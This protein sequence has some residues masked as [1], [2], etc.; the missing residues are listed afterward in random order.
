MWKDEKICL[1]QKSC[2]FIVGFG[3]V[4]V[5]LGPWLDVGL[6]CCWFWFGSWFPGQLWSS[7]CTCLIIIPCLGIPS[8]C[9][10][11]MVGF[12]SWLF[13][14][15]SL[16]L[17]LRFS[18]L[19]CWV[20]GLWSWSLCLVVICLFALCFVIFLCIML[21][22]V[23]ASCVDFLAAR[24]TSLRVVVLCVVWFCVLVVVVDMLASC[25]SQNR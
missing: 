22:Y 23:L 2:S 16:V 5:L 4:L 9:L 6:C 17:G 21:C 15:E 24:A 19:W 12:W 14:L 8:I 7:I 1:C 10:F 25:M 13:G 11:V 18:G 20:F 3:W